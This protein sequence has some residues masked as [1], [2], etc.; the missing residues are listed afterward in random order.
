MQTSMEVLI[1]ARP[2]PTLWILTALAEF[3]AGG[4]SCLEMAAYVLTDPAELESKIKE[5]R[6]AIEKDNFKVLKMMVSK[7][8]QELI[9]KLIAKESA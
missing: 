2:I 1:E 3:P 6:E 8:E 5:F 4:N 9:D 7:I